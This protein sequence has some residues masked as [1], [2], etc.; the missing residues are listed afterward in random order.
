MLS[1]SRKR[2]AFGSLRQ[3]SANVSRFRLH[4][5]SGSQA[6]LTIV[7]ILHQKNFNC[8]VQIGRLAY[9]IRE[10]RKHM[11]ATRRRI[12][13][14]NPISPRESTPPTHRLCHASCIMQCAR[15]SHAAFQSFA[16]FF[17]DPWRQRGCHHLVFREAVY[18][19][20]A[21]QSS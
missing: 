17:Q 14:R 11:T 15:R 13:I 7:Q 10:A 19:F 6:S 5:C 21:I 18:F 4:P 12:H 20:C 16:G 9:E 3:C 1:M 8:T 2:C